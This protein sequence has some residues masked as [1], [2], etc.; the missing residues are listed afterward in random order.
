MKYCRKCSSFKPR[1]QF[2]LDPRTRD[3][4]RGTC[5]SCGRAYVRS[6]I[7]TLRH[8]ALSALGNQCFKCGFSDY[9]ALQIDH[10]N[11]G[12]LAHRKKLGS[13][14]GYYRSIL[15]DLSRYQ[16]LCAN[17]NWIKRYDNQE[18]RRILT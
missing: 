18:N 6:Y 2:V 15:K 8:K 4:H 17:C 14:T 1:D 3:G 13:G 5:K 7:S 16:L 11:G 12:G 10:I 9:R